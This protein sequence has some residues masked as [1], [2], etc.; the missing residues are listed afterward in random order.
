[1][2]GHTDL[3]YLLHANARRFRAQFVA[4]LRALDLT[5]QQAGVLIAMAC[6]EP[7]AWSPTSV[8][9]AIDADAPT[10]TGLL[11]RLERDGWLVSE[12]HPSDGRSRLFGLTPKAHD[13]MPQVFAAADG[14]SSAASAELNADEVA[15]LAS[16]LTRMLAPVRG[17]R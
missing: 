1:M 6:G 17:S 11:S 12:P 16:L 15:L 5:A 2:S 7:D 3:G 10:T 14:A 9:A 13:V 8:A 4:A